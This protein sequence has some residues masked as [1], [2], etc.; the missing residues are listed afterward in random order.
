MMMSSGVAAAAEYRGQRRRCAVTA[1]EKRRGLWLSWRSVRLTVTRLQRTA[2]ALS[3][4]SALPH[5][6]TRRVCEPTRSAVFNGSQSPPHPRVHRPSSIVHRPSSIIP[7]FAHHLIVSSSHCHH[8]RSLVVSYYNS[9]AGGLERLS[10]MLA[11]LPT[12][13]PGQWTA[14]ARHA[15][16]RNQAR[17]AVS[18]LLGAPA[19]ALCADVVTSIKMSRE[20]ALLGSYSPLTTRSPS[21]HTLSPPAL[22]THLRFLPSSSSISL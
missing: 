14:S 6:P 20:Y 2:T 3:L 13:P 5:R 18:S 15:R 21:I 22:S 19:A 8:N 7:A 11:M 9:A 16:R 12:P 17:G 4:S 1:A 10:V